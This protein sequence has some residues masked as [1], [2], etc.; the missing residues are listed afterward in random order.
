LK[1]DLHKTNYRT[2]QPL[3]WVSDNWILCKLAPYIY[4][5][6][7]FICDIA[8]PLVPPL[9]RGGLLDWHKNCILFLPPET[10]TPFVA[11]STR[12][13]LFM[14]NQ[15]EKY[16][17]GVTLELQPTLYRFLADTDDLDSVQTICKGAKS[18]L[19]SQGVSLI[20][21]E[22]NAW[23]CSGIEDLNIIRALLAD[24][25]QGVGGICPE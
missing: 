12:A 6:F 14:D 13:I 24:F 4:T 8:P 18:Y 10:I 16:R 1:A 7:P 9:K 25:W 2:P 19:V 3:C 22:L 20:D 11:L 15:I 23:I 21:Y 17:F 5:L